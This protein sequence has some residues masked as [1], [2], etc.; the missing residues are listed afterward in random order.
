MR[1]PYKIL[2]R[3]LARE[4]CETITAAFES[5]NWKKPVSL[6]ERYLAEC[7]S[8]ER[9]ILIAE[10]DG[11]FA[12]YVTIDWRPEYPVFK[13]QS[14]PEIADFNVLKKFQSQGVG[15]RLMES[16]EQ[17]ISE[18]SDRAGIRVGLTADYGNAQRLYVKRG[19]IPDGHGIS[20][21]GKF[22]IYGDAVTV[23]DDLTIGFT[24][25]LK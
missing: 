18:R 13:E 24:K 7:S 23:D 25:S 17:L 22:L 1:S 21:R 9:T 4:D 8:G 14:I 5:Q 11:Q 20:Q 10:L 15:T 16:A 3:P 6:F 12:G 2:I 19:Y